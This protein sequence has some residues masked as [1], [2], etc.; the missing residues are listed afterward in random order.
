MRIFKINEL[1]EI[2]CLFAILLE[3]N[4]STITNQIVIIVIGLY[5]VAACKVAAQFADYGIYVF[6]RDIWIDFIKGSF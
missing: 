1:D 2:E 4:F 5:H 3:L 6:S